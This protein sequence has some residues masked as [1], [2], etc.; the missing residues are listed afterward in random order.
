MY[1]TS[2]GDSRR[3]PS[4]RA[5]SGNPPPPRKSRRTNGK[6]RWR[7]K[8][9]D[10]RQHGHHHAFG[11]TSKR[12]GFAAPKSKWA[13][14]QKQEEKPLFKPGFFSL[15]FGVLLP[16][17]AVVF[18]TQTHYMAQTNF[19]P[20]PS[21][22]H[23]VLFLLIPLSNFLA[24]LAVRYNLKAIYSIMALASGMA[25]GVGI[26]YS[27]M[28]LPMTPMFAFMIFAIVGLLGLSPLFSLPV[29]MVSGKTIC[30]LADKEGTFF[31]AHQLKHLGHLIILVMVISIELPSTLTRINLGL[32]DSSDSKE[33]Q[34]QAIVWLREWGNREVL[35][36]A[37]YERSGRATDILG[38]LAENMHPV[39]V[40]RAR[41]IYYQVA[42]V[43]FNSVPIPPSFRGTIQHAGLIDDPAGLNGNVKDEFDLDPDIAGEL[44]SG[45]ARGLS[46]SQSSLTGLLSDDDTASL[47]W[48]F[49]FENVSDLPREARAKIVLPPDA[50]VTRATL[51]LDDYE[52]ETTIMPRGLARETYQQSVISHKRD[53]LLVSMAGKDTVL[54]Q[55][56]PVVKG[57]LTKIRLHITAPLQVINDK[58]D[59]LM[60]PTFDE[61][62]FAVSKPYD[63]SLIS[64]SSLSIPALNHGG[65][66]VVA[67]TP[68]LKATIDN[69][70]LARFAA[71]VHMDRT[72]SAP[73][74]SQPSRSISASDTASSTT[75]QNA[76]PTT[77]PASFKRGIFIILDQSSAMSAYIKDVIKGLQSA[78]D[79]PISVV[80][81]VDGNQV[82]CANAKP[83]DKAFQ[84]ML[85]NLEKTP[86]QGGQCDQSALSQALYA[87]LYIEAS[88]R[89]YNYMQQPRVNAH[90]DVLWIHAA[91]PM[92]E[93]TTDGIDN[94]LSQ[95]SAGGPVLYDLQ[96]ASGPNALLTDSYRF[97]ALA[98]V[99]RTGALA[100]DISRFFKRWSDGSLLKPEAT[101]GPPNGK[102]SSKER[103]ELDAY[104]QSIRLFQQGDKFAAYN[105]ALQYH[106]VT[107]ISS[108]VVAED[109]PLKIK[110]MAELEKEKPQRFDMPNPSASVQKMRSEINRQLDSL[111][112]AAGS[113]SGG[114]GGEEL[115]AR[116]TDLFMSISN[117]VSTSTAGYQS[118]MKQPVTFNSR[119]TDKGTAGGVTDQQWR[120]QMPAG[121]AG[122][123]AQ[124][125]GDALTTQGQTGMVGRGLDIG[126]QS[127]D[128][129]YAN[130]A[131]GFFKMEERSKSCEAQPQEGVSYGQKSHAF[132]DVSS[133]VA[134]GLGT[135]VALLLAILVMFF[136]SLRN[137]DQ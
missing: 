30:Q 136:R 124:S 33:A 84:N 25:M 69:S 38:S 63:V 114:G 16:I 98:R 49:T 88:S 108:A 78:P 41:Q 105:V 112:A 75:T 90:S 5:S 94:L 92:T 111:S 106:L 104:K 35:L 22:F 87:S 123:H 45:V 93:G 10:E 74:R 7:P 130:K 34:K 29:S 32:A 17:A 51:W 116:R 122:T 110:P 103:A 109:I 137:N 19:D 62:N 81:V 129:K 125:F 97:A 83:S 82:L 68:N 24:W 28:L 61:R 9:A 55:C 117:S 134:V 135:L 65:A 42:G 37:C 58:D 99:P 86:C 132:L 20:F 27:L 11:E 6:I 76:V 64:R 59:A 18:E 128:G 36:R 23:V 48:T 131:P 57:T 71:V 80:T 91:Q 89:N 67:K 52:K 85:A 39:G 47:D 101:I 44:V 4:S 113:A 3:N 120:S 96:V 40:E 26:L 79:A 8:R 133:I 95:M 60:L 56:Y 43:A 31:D 126:Q 70:M 2:A 46:A 13:E 72:A 119:E 115:G 54:V 50:V 12:V 100:E 53:P 118:E 15:V 77:K 73:W 14:P 121:K 107:P 1:R 102:K 127:L 21:G 66:P